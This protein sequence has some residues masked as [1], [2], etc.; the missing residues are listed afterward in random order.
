MTSAEAAVCAAVIAVSA[1]CDTQVSPVDV[2][3][4]AGGLHAVVELAE[5]VAARDV[6]DGAEPLGTRDGDIE[7]APLFFYAARA[8]L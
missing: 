4:E 7:Q 3:K 1:V 6:G 5:V 2:P 8:V